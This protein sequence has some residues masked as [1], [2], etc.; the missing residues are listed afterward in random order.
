MACCPAEC[1]AVDRSARIIRV[2][3][4]RVR[5]SGLLVACGLFAVALL[6]GCAA[7]ASGPPDGSVHGCTAYAYRSIQRHVRVTSLPAE[8]GGLTPGQ[9]SLAASTAIRESATAGGGIGKAELRRRA[10][11]AAPWVSVL[12]RSVPP[13]RQS[14]VPALAGSAGAGGGR[15][16]GVSEFAV[17]LAALLA[18]LATAAS[19]AYVLVR[20]LLAGGSLRGRGGASAPP[21][22][23]AGHAGIGLAGLVAWSLFTITGW[24][25]LAWICL[26]MLL[27]VT[28]LGMGV[29]LLGLPRPTRRVATV[30]SGKRKRKG[31]PWLMIAGH[32]IAAATLLILVITATIAVAL[33][34]PSRVAC[35]SSARDLTCWRGG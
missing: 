13:A 19:G 6:T 17:Q 11:E 20:W 15:L 25:W 2:L 10:T 8:C 3:S 1:R 28:G 16:G 26:V 35:A 12:I 34:K 32:G 29:L 7:S 4:I 31:P 30:R 14:P 23:T 22:V 9:V 27:P 24:A 18:W 33:R 21:A 5:S